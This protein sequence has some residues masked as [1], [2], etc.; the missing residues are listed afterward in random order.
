MAY[1]RI[2]LLTS[3]VVFLCG[4]DDDGYVV[5][6]VS[7]QEVRD[8]VANIKDVSI[9]AGSTAK[10]INSKGAK[11]QSELTIKI[12]GDTDKIKKLADLAQVKI[13]DAQVKINVNAKQAAKIGTQLNKVTKELN[14]A[15]A[16]INKRD[17]L[18]FKLYLTIFGMGLLAVLYIG[19]KSGL[20]KLIFL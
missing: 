8:A 20:W 12:V 2:F 17:A 18:I 4:C 1:L 3:L 13:K 16:T 9:D 10:E 7:L 14:Q 19:F 15:N 11:P 6:T 5:T